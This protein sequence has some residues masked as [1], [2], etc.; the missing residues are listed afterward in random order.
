MSASSRSTW[1]TP[2]RALV[3]CEQRGDATARNLF[4]VREAAGARAA[5]HAGG[6]RFGHRRGVESLDVV[7]DAREEDDEIVGGRDVAFQGRTDGFTPGRLRVDEMAVAHS[8]R[9]GGALRRERAFSHAF[10]IGMCDSTLERVGREQVR[11]HF[12]MSAA[13]GGL[14][15]PPVCQSGAAVILV[16]VVGARLPDLRRPWPAQRAERAKGLRGNG[17]RLLNGFQP[18]LEPG[19]APARFEPPDHT[20]SF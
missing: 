19:S 12:R 17:S 10:H 15:S 18:D 14:E 7:I 8:G 16:F 9:D 5:E 6:R 3:G 13:F 1:Q 11:P 4:R 2:K 20:R